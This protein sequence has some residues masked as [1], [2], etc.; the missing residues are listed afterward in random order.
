[1]RRQA[2]SGFSPPSIGFSGRNRSRRAIRGIFGRAGFFLRALGLI[3]FSA[4]YSLLFQIKGLIGPNGILPAGDYL[5]AVAAALHGA[6]FWF[7]PTLLWL[8]SSDQR[9]DACCA[10]RDSLASLLLVLNVWPRGDARDL[11][12]LLSFLCLPR[13]RISPAINRTECC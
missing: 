11:L 2:W 6:R 1:M 3:Y 7:A 8:G 12:R 5:Q 10:G 13:R 9:A 4:F